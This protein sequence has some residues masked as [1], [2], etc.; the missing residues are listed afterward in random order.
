MQR[1]FSTLYFIGALTVFIGAAAAQN[2][3]MRLCDQSIETVA[4]ST[5]VPKSVLL[6][7]ARLE[8]GRRVQ[9]QMVSW[10]W[11]LN[12]SGAGY[13]FSSKSGA[14]EK[15]QKLMAAGKKNIDVGCM[16]LNIRWHARYFNSTSAMLSPFEN[17][18]YAAKYLEQLYRETGSWEKTIKYYHS[19]NP[20]F[21]SVYYA[22][23]R[24]MA[25]PDLRQLSQPLLASTDQGVFSILPASARD[26]NSLIWVVPQGSLLFAGKAISA[27]A[28]TD[29]REFRVAPLVPSLQ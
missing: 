21:N 18:S 20:K 15:L 16:Q 8:S 23:F 26:K 7:I 4:K 2:L 3:D 14:S 13:F 17:V 1:I 19:R 29:I 22:K 25:E 11:T 12:N 27:P 24:D 9:D 10:P 5:F 28:F 6:K